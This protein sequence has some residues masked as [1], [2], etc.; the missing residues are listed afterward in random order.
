MDK[1]NRYEIKSLPSMFG[2]TDM[3]V[4]TETFVLGA[5]RELCEASSNEV[6]EDA[7]VYRVFSPL[8]QEMNDLAR[9]LAKTK[10][11]L[12]EARAFIDE[13]RRAGDK[14]QMAC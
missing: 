14:N 7:S 10:E 2:D 9:E 6:P 3:V 1:N 8:L 4:D 5:P 12:I 13:L 11:E